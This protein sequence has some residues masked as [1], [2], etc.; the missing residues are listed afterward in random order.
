MHS[1]IQFPNARKVCEVTV[2]H[3]RV[4]SIPTLGAKYK[5]GTITQMARA[6]PLKR[7][8]PSSMLGGPTK[9]K[10]YLRWPETAQ[11]DLSDRSSAAEQRTFNS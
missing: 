1:Q 11:G 4:G 7:L 8:D 9:Y 3:L 6:S 2:N 10:S 5:N